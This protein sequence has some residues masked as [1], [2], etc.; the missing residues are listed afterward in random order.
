M[1]REESFEALATVPYSQPSMGM[2]I[3][4]I[5]VQPEHQKKLETW[6]AE[7]SGQLEPIYEEPELHGSIQRFA[8]SER[9]ILSQLISMLIRKGM[10]AP[11]EGSALLH[12][13]SAHVNR[14]A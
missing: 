10:L 13:L 7:L 8:R 2:G 9:D 6:I 1:H 11:S 14:Q 12:E 5:G 3:G 4:F